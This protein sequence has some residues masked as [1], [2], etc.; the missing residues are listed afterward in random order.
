V[1]WVLLLAVDSTP[2]AL[3]IASGTDCPSATEVVRQIAA[4]LPAG[5][6]ARVSGGAPV[7]GVDQAQIAIE[8]GARWVRLRGSG[9]RWNHE[10]SLPASLGCGQAA[11]AAA[12]LIATWE[13]Q[14]RGELPPLGTLDAMPGVVVELDRNVPPAAT[15]PGA[16]GERSPTPTPTSIPTATARPAVTASAAPANGSATGA[17]TPAGE[18]RAPTPPAPGAQPVGAGTTSAPLGGPEGGVDRPAPPPRRLG[19]GAGAG[20]GWA[21]RQAVAGG[22]LEVTFGPAVGLGLRLQGMITGRSSVALGSGQ[23][24]WT[25]RSLGIGTSLTL[26]PRRVGAQVHADLLAARF[27][28]AGQNFAAN[29]KGVQAALGVAIGGRGLVALGAGDL[30][31]DLTA[32]AWPGSHQA[33]VQGSNILIELPAAEIGAALGVDFFL[34]P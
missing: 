30:W 21:A 33:A 29:Q 8:D 4:L 1:W 15:G 32:T 28:M 10:R 9:E 14:G 24:T 12:V 7:A 18:A 25:R 20:I 23:A 26:R 22:A 27:A 2:P 34:W 31:L 16:A 5:M 19:V 11:R 3:E 13:F 17:G 6:T